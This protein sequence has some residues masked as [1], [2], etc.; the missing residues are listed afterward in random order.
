MSSRIFARFSRYKIVQRGVLLVLM[1]FSLPLAAQPPVPKPATLF[2]VKGQPCY[3][4]EF[5][6]LFKKNHPN[7]ADYTQ[8]KVEAYFTL[9]VNFKLKVAEAKSRG[10]DTTRAFQKEFNTYK[11]ELKK[12]YL[13]TADEVEQLAHEAYERLQE[14][15]RA[16][17]ILLSVKPEATPADTLSVFM[18]IMGIRDRIVAGEDFGT[19]AAQHSEDPSAKLNHGNLGYFTAL[20]MVYPF[21]SAVYRLRKGEVSMP[22]RTR[23]GYHLIKVTDRQAARGEVEVSHI[24]LRAGNTNDVK[25]KN[26]IFE[27]YDQLQAGRSW[28]E[29]CRQYSDDPGTKNQG[30]RLRPFGV[31]AMSGVPEF[32]RVAFSLTQPGEIS[33]P[34]QSSYGWHILR[35]EKKIPLPPYEE[36]AASLKRKIGRDDRLRLAHRKFLSDRKKAEHCSEDQA[37]LGEVMALAD[38]TL[39]K[40]KW[41]R[42]AGFSGERKLFS[43][44]ENTYTAGAFLAYVEKNQ[45]PNSLPP[46]QYLGELYDRFVEEKLNQEEEARILRDHAELRNLLTEYREGILL[47]SIMET[48]VWN[49]ASADTAALKNYYEAHRDKYKAGE[50]VRARII[51]ATDESAFREVAK[52]V[53]Q[54]DTVTRADIKRMKAVLPFRNYERGENK[55]IDKIDWSVGVHETNI[56]GTFYLVEISTLLT[57]GI[58]TFSEA[59]PLVISDYQDQLEKNWVG[60]LKRKYP[61]RV[62]N[63][64]KKNVIKELTRS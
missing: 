1:A 6:Y 20:Q 43:L 7:A 48:E 25:L 8:E 45:K 12:P 37:I 3:S 22:V 42:P 10:L 33:D 2:S 18:K 14:E 44:P 47:F 32:E 24:I 58:K 9:F 5:I 21:E 51:S 34:F 64:T 39:T 55:A 31:G 19:L 16:S 57:A 49:K 27:I 50:R 63:G 60:A 54:G 17:H 40:G 23:F 30:G 61:V 11:D 35:L 41:K 52:K 62:N 26:K 15:V 13:A 4:D 29:L 53:A 38:S 36:L 46:S 59:K 56:E 28:D